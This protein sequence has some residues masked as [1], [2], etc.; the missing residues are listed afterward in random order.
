MAHHEEGNEGYHFKQ[1]HRQ[2]TIDGQ[3]YSNQPGKPNDDD[4]LD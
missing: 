1:S 2:A 4:V 3:I